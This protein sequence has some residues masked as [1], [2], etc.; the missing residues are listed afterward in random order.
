MGTHW[1]PGNW[2]H[3]KSDKESKIL[4]FTCC[5]TWTLKVLN[6]SISAGKIFQHF[7]QKIVGDT[8]SLESYFICVPPESTTYVWDFPLKTRYDP[9]ATVGFES[10]CHAII[11]SLKWAMT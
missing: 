3:V 7:D 4:K 11:L 5:E 2:F 1:N 9:S 10:H 8:E 6:S